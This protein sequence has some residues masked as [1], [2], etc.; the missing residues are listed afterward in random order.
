MVNVQQPHMNDS[1]LDVLLASI[2]AGFAILDTGATTSVVGAETTAR[3]AQH[4][5]AQ[6]FPPPVELEMPPVELCDSCGAS[7]L[8]FPSLTPSCFRFA[9]VA[10]H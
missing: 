1:E 9:M 6:G 3:Y 4:F 2:P 7:A 5:A 8:S 10:E